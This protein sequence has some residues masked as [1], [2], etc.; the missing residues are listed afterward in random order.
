MVAL[1]LCAVH[2]CISRKKSAPEVSYNGE[3]G[4]VFPLSS[5]HDTHSSW[6]ILQHFT[7]HQNCQYIAERN[8]KQVESVKPHK[9]H[10]A[11]HV[12]LLS[13]KNKIFHL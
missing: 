1:S 12:D 8:K 5:L 2:I 7:A 13:S 10:V 9:S 6:D 4:T 3:L 11:K